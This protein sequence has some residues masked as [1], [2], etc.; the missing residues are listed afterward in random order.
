MPRGDGTGPMGG[1]PRGGGRGMGGGQGRGRRGGL[2]AGV[3]GEC[4]CPS[5]GTKV[6][7]Q[8]GIPCNTVKCP[9]CGTLMTRAM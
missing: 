4:I 1:G 3:G 5:C 8:R 9:K 2:G 7:H 6:P